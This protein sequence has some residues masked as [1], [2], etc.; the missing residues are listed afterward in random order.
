MIRNIDLYIYT[1]ICHY[2]NIFLRYILTVWQFVMNSY[3]A[4]NLFI[5]L[6]ALLCMILFF[7]FVAHFHF[8]RAH[9]NTLAC[10]CMCVYECVLFCYCT[11]Y[12]KKATI[13]K[14]IITSCFTNTVYT[15][16]CKHT[17]ILRHWKKQNSYM[18]SWVVSRLSS[19]S[20]SLLSSGRSD[21]FKLLA[22]IGMTT[23]ITH[24]ICSLRPMATN[25]AKRTKTKCI[26]SSYAKW[27][28]CFV[29]NFTIITTFHLL[30]KYVHAIVCM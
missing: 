23:T 24:S 11:M 8:V 21:C 10:V 12:A 5:L 6:H 3:L 30:H 28:A 4:L 7:Q 25:T 17:N 26:N 13:I 20:S 1:Y 15:N 27:T 19:L 14:H 18:S 2:I 16:A 9:I 29:P 22:C